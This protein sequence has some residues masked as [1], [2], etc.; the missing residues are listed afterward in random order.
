MILHRRH[1]MQNPSVGALV[2][3]ATPVCLVGRSR[4]LS[5]RYNRYSM[6]DTPCAIL[7]LVLVVSQPIGGAQSMS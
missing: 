6:H 7:G 2:G 1:R 3:T 5:S 4:A